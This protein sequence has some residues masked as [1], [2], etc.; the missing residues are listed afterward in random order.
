MGL[1]P[2]SQTQAGSG[3]GTLEQSACNAWPG[4]RNADHAISS[5]LQA[6]ASQ[7][8]HEYASTPIAHLANVLAHLRFD[9]QFRFAIVRLNL[10]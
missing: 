1:V 8:I 2:R 5:P 10:L 9:L 7:N 4:T 6:T 3:L